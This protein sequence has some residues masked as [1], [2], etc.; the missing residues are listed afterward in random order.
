MSLSWWHWGTLNLQLRQLASNSPQSSYMNKYYRMQIRTKMKNLWVCCIIP[1]HLL[2][3]WICDLIMFT[4]SNR[5]FWRTTAV[6]GDDGGCWGDCIISG[7]GY[8][9]IDNHFGNNGNHGH[10]QQ[11]IKYEKNLPWYK[12]TK[13][14]IPI[15][16]QKMVLRYWQNHTL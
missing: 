2:R 16:F 4:T 12:W 7:G 15:E 6:R 5:P 14:Y 3:L 11:P 13:L 10:H 1:S 9:F 8:I